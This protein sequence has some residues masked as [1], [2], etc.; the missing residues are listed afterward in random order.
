M[1][2]P[3]KILPSQY[4]LYHR[5]L[6]GHGRCFRNV[7]SPQHQSSPELGFQGIAA[8]ERDWREQY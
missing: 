1:H 6:S 8:R 4:P 3:V 7:R 5:P 2:L